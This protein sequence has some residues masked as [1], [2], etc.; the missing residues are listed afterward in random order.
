MRKPWITTIILTTHDIGDIEALCKRVVIIDK[1]KV[2]FDDEMQKVTGLF[3]AYRT[4]R[5]QMSPLLPDTVK[6]FTA[7][8]D[9]TFNCPDGYTIA[10]DE[11]DW[12][13]VTINQDKL[14]LRNVLNFAMEQ[15][16]VNDVQI[17]EIATE[18]VIQKI[19]E[20]VSQ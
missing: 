11:N 19:Y 17:A 4:L 16:P 5:L 13:N 10:S 2:I 7:K 8:L 3:G 15:F 12:L 20:G 1:G 14:P 18:S 9:S 6:E